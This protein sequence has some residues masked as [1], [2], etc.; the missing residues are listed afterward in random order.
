M[1]VL[2]FPIVDLSTRFPQLFYT[3]VGVVYGKVPSNPEGNL[4]ANGGSF[5]TD[6][7]GNGYLKTTDN[8]ATGWLAIG[9]GGSGTVTSVGLTAPSALFVSPV[10]GSPVTTSGTL[11]LALATQNANRVFAGPATGVPATPTFRTLTNADLIGAA[12][13]P[14]NGI[15]FNDGTN[16]FT[17]ETDLLFDPATGTLQL[18]VAGTR[19]GRAQWRGAVSGSVTL[20]VNQ[21]SSNHVVTMPD[22]LPTLNDLLTASAVSGSNVTWGWTSRASI[23]AALVNSANIIPYSTGSALADSQLTRTSS[24]MLTLTTGQFDLPAGTTSAP[25]I[26]F[27]SN[28]FGFSK[29]GNAGNGLIATVNG[30]PEFCLFDGNTAFVG[31]NTTRQYCW[32]TVS[33]ASADT[34]WARRQAGVIRPTNGSTGV[35]QILV[36]GSADTVIGQLHVNSQNAGVEAGYFTMP[37]SPTVPMIR[38]VI[39]SIQSF[40]LMG[41]GKLVGGCN[42]PTA[43]QQFSARGNFGIDVSELGNVGAGATNLLSKSVIANSV[44]NNG[45]KVNFKTSFLYANNANNKQVE[46]TFAGQSVFLIS[47]AFQNSPGHLE[48]DIYRTSSTTAKVTSRYASSDALLKSDYQYYELTGLNWA[49]GQTLQVKGTATSN[50]DIINKLLESNITVAL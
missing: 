37:T 44:A 31:I 17:A 5:V 20:T 7:S 8:A 24:T 42:I 41:S 18:G 25:A 3:D 27:T 12:P 6:P 33:T 1:S 38:G 32:G 46:V 40:G 35:G 16:S 2:A 29:A 39:S 34:G 4:I 11:A 15:P 47:D 30:N 14:T 50:N 19:A 36:G 9:G 43:N 10:S 26:R 28:S 21:P 45:D 22:A 48:I 49:T 23:A 13:P